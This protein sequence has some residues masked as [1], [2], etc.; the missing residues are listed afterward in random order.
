MCLFWGR[1]MFFMNACFC[2]LKEILFWDVNN[3]A[4]VPELKAVAV[5][6]GSKV[7]AEL[8]EQQLGES[9]LDSGSECKF[10]VWLYTDLCYRVSGGKT[11]QIIGNRGDFSLWIWV[12]GC[13]KQHLKILVTF[14]HNLCW[15][16]DVL[17]ATGGYCHCFYGFDGYYTKLVY[18]E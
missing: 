11:C 14:K 17:Y 8:S 7:P 4:I 9:L 18:C 1:I 10:C 13:S 12:T 2:I 16:W 5:T 3:Y 6:G 15:S